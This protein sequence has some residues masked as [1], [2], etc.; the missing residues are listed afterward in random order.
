MNDKYSLNSDKIL[1]MIEDNQNHLWLASYGTGL[2]YYD[3][4]TNRFISPEIDYKKNQK[5][6]VAITVDTTKSL[7]WAATE[8]GGVFQYNYQ[9]QRKKDYSWKID[10]QNHS[11][12]FASISLIDNYIYAGNSVGEV[13]EIDTNLKISNIY[14]VS[15]SVVVGIQKYKS[16]LFISTMSD[17][18]F[19]YNKT[20]R[21]KNSIIKSKQ[22]LATKVI[23]SVNKTSDSTYIISTQSGIQY[24][25]LKNDTIIVDKSIEK[26][27]SNLDYESF[28][29]SFVD[30]RG[31]EWFGSNGFGLFYKNKY[32]DLFNTIK[33]NNKDESLTFSSIRAIHK[34][35]DEL[36]IGGYGGINI[37][38]EK[39]KKIR[40]I[41]SI[42]K[43]SKDS[44]TGDWSNY[45]YNN[46]IYNFYQDPLD[47]DLIWIGTEGFGM[48][49]Y[50]KRLKKFKF[51][52]FGNKY[53]KEDDIN[54]IFKIDRYD[55]NF[56]LGTSDGVYAFEPKSETL[57]LLNV[58][59]QV[60][61]KRIL[62]VKSLFQENGNIFLIVDGIGAFIYKLN[63]TTLIPITNY[64]PKLDKNI[65]VN[66]NSI[67]K[68]NNKILLGT[69]EQ[70]LFILDLRDSTYKNYY[71]GNGL[72]NNCVYEVIVDGDYL[73]VSTNKGISKIDIK[74]DAIVN[75]SSKLF[76]LN[77]EYNLN[78]AYK[79]NNELLY[80]GG[81]DGV[82]W[83]DPQLLTNLE[84]KSGLIIKS[85]E[86][87]DQDNV[88]YFYFVD[89]DTLNIGYIDDLVEINF[90]TNEYLIA[91]GLKYEC[92]LNKNDWQLV[93]NNKI[94][95]IGMHNGKN[96][97][98]V[99][100]YDEKGKIS[101]T[102][103]FYI[104]VSIPFWKT[105]WFKLLIVV[106]LLA[107]VYYSYYNNIKKLKSKLLKFG[108]ENRSIKKYG[109]ELTKKLDLLNNNLTNVIW[110]TDKYFNINYCSSNLYEYYNVNKDKE[111]LN[112]SDLYIID[113]LLQLKEEI[114]EFKL[115]HNKFER[116]LFHKNSFETEKKYSE[117]K[118]KIQI[119]GIGE[120]I[121]LI[122]VVSDSKE[123]EKA[124]L[125][126][127]EREELF[128]TLVETILEPVLITSW[129]GEIL[130]AN[131]EAK[132]ILEIHQRNMYEKTLFDYFDDPL[133]HEL[134]KDIYI[135]K[136]GE[137]F[138][139]K[140]F[141]LIVN[142]KLKTIE[143]N[144]TSIIYYGRKVF[145]F[146]FRDVTQRINL[147]NELTTAKIEAERSSELKTMYLSNLTH[148][149]KT[150]INAISGF[151]DIIQSKNK[152]T[153]YNS[154]L[155][156]IKQGTNLL[157]QLINDLLFYTKAESGKL[158]LRPVPTNI[159]KLV[160]E[161]ESIFAIEIKEKQLKFTK[162]INTN[163]IEHLLNL[164]QL[165]FKQI[166][167]NLLNNAIKYTDEGSISLTISISNINKAQVDLKMIVEDTGRGIPEHRLR[168][169]FTAFRQVNFSDEN[170][171]FGL[172]LA[173][174][175]RILDSMNGKITVE[176]TIDKGSKFIV[177]IRKIN[178]VL[179]KATRLKKAKEFDL[180]EKFIRR[181]DNLNYYS[182]ETL[183]E[184]YKLMEGRFTQ[185][186]KNIKTNFL[187]KD[188][189]DFAEQ[190]NKVASDRGIEFLTKYSNELLE[191][192]KSIEVEKINNLLENFYKLVE[193]IR[194]L[195]E[196]WNGKKQR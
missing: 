136:S 106:L 161:L 16:Q 63:Q 179:N 5:L 68:Y 143:G 192:T 88:E 170:E 45:I 107:G 112:L 71:Y 108:R 129:E 3:Y 116:K 46:S 34:F 140:Q 120:Y 187:L 193:L 43:S 176:S 123:K 162:Q 92:R 52:K 177:E 21:L 167:I 10:N 141:N 173:I 33:K 89:G 26:N 100:V 156:S 82:V 84:F 185:K 72:N 30:S 124:K 12:E 122:G 148:E 154:Y 166:I 188:I 132:N 40:E 32:F 158:E 6:I 114:Q 146:T 181:D 168:E 31:T 2:T 39:T 191:A 195:I 194:K 101:E 79:E 133:N 86:F 22:L 42:I 56:I 91:T 127:Q 13:L 24:L 137:S 54:S 147:I 121:G 172:G 102:K 28:L 67:Q 78:A 59:N 15:E 109:S 139:K 25:I 75:F 94:N 9:S 174:V 87:N 35:G 83:F 90:I 160:S 38:N 48:Y 119:N 14:K 29:C 76:E 180:V 98:E 164:D 171:G 130:F 151:T 169:I 134:R 80:F 62:N 60:L 73:W 85:V 186:L 53:G 69:K 97:V 11:N 117:V 18:Y 17:N 1:D 19:I 49:K 144:G 27:N 44:I 145:L 182:I 163:G 155:D 70:G 128:S 135:V 36:W 142:N 55:N 81:T 58:I 65:F 50:S 47:S 153:S 111:N 157:L 125:Q 150:P 190:L 183:E 110:Q 51:I 66:S 131:N 138:I 7:I 74:S 20:D 57:S 41:P 159:N 118:I 184:I 105:L 8:G 165:K 113:D 189:T 4:K 152:D 77:S 93:K 175:K 104:I 64:Y 126:L 61:Q 99:R 96:K 115:F 95:L 196:K 178:L 37:L 149:L 103:Y 23:T